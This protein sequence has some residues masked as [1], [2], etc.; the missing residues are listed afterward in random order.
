MKGYDGNR[1]ENQAVVQQISGTFENGNQKGPQGFTPGSYQPKSVPGS[2]YSTY[3]PMYKDNMSRGVFSNVLLQPSQSGS[4]RRLS[5]SLSQRK[6]FHRQSDG[7][8]ISENSTALSLLQSQRSSTSG[9]SAYT[10]ASVAKRILDTLSELQ[11]PMEEARQRP[12]SIAAAL[13]ASKD[14]LARTERAPISSILTSTSNSDRKVE[15]TSSK[16]NSFLSFPTTSSVGP[17]AVA[18]SVSTSTSTSSSSSFASTANIGNK[19]S[20]HVTPSFSF[21]STP[22]ILS[23]AVPLQSTDFFQDKGYSYKASAQIPMKS[24]LVTSLPFQSIPL[25]KTPNTVR[26][27]DS[28]SEFVF[29][30]PSQVEG[31]DSSEMEK[32]LSPPGSMRKDDKIKFAFSPPGKSATKRKIGAVTNQT[33]VPEKKFVSNEISQVRL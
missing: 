6:K 18:A 16:L 9:S 1:H 24:P 8:N 5:L 29:G 30:E 17:A 27:V 21:Q 32:I 13:T 26:F 7:G 33:S 4:T 3:T 23:P 2:S 19:S 22:N 31:V 11:T 10:S 28:D 14:A 15:M 12:I 20:Q 25:P